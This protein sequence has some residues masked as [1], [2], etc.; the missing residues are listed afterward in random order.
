MLELLSANTCKGKAACDARMKMKDLSLMRKKEIAR[1]R[2]D[3]LNYR[4][5]GSVGLCWRRPKG[6]VGL[7]HDVCIA[8]K[9]EVQDISMRHR[10]SDL[11]RHTRTTGRHRSYDSYFARIYKLKLKMAILVRETKED[12]KGTAR[13]SA[14]W[15]RLGR[16]TS[17]GADIEVQ[18]LRSM[19]TT[20]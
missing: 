13:A 6:T 8:T 9:N 14:R 4:P 17:A 12:A 1:K 19:V 15:G 2:R 18:S 3:N 5:K 7:C 11:R 10:L 20:R 16:A